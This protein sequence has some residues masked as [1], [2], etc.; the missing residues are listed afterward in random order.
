MLHVLARIERYHTLNF[1]VN[2]DN[3][4]RV[5]RTVI[6]DFG[7]CLLGY[8]QDERFD[9]VA[10]V[11]H[12]LVFSR[13]LRNKTYFG[14][15][16]V[17]S[18]IHFPAE[19]GFDGT[20]TCF[21]VEVQFQF[22]VF[23]GC[24]PAGLVCLEFHFVLIGHCFRFGKGVL[25]VLLVYQE[26]DIARYDCLEKALVVSCRTFYFHIWFFDYDLLAE[27]ELGNGNQLGFLSFQGET[28]L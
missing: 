26:V 7:R 12:Q 6:L 25:N 2:G 16:G 28:D 24:N 8:C 4:Q 22:R 1:L 9:R 27:A 14:Y 17:G 13:V 18:C 10:V 19:F 20:R 5:A 11:V 21:P 15:P 3:G 23:G